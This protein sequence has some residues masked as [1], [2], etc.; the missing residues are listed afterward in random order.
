MSDTATIKV[1][2]KAKGERPWFFEDP[3]IDKVLSIA[4]GLAGEVAVLHDRL[5]TIERLVEQKG[6]LSR[7]EIEA[8]YPPEAVRAERDIWRDQFLRQVL[9]ILHE[10]V[11]GLETGAAEKTYKEAIKVAAS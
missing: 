2:R 5:D 6:L 1:R 7:S 9:R 3:A 8:Y 11:E 4:M 10:E